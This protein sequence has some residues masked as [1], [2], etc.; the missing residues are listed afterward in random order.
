[1][2]ARQS[3]AASLRG[4]V[5]PV[6]EL[7]ATARKP[8]RAIA[9]Y[10]IPTLV[11]FLI[12][13]VGLW[14]LPGT[15]W[16]M[17]GND[18]GIWA[19]WNLSGIF[20]WSMP[21]DLSPFNPL[22]G[23]GST[24]LPNTP[25]LN[26]AA[27]AL[28]LPFPREITYL[29]SYFLYFAELTA[30]TVA[31]FRII[32]LSPL[33]SVI[34]TQIYLLVLFPP[35]NG[36]FQSLYWYS[37]APV[38]AHLVAVANTLLILLLVIGGFRR[39]GNIACGLA[40]A[41]LVLCGLFSA[42]V[43]FLTYAPTYGLAAAALLL[44]RQPDSRQ[45]LWKVGAIA[46]TAFLLWIAGF[47]DYLAATSLVSARATTFPPAFAAGAQI[48]SW[49][50]WRPALARFDVC[51][52]AQV[53]LCARYPIFWIMAGSL[54]GAAACAAR[55]SNLRPLAIGM[56]AYVVGVHIWAVADTVSLFG[57]AH[58]ISPPYLIWAAYPFTALFLG[59]LIFRLIDLLADPC[60]RFSTR[61]RGGV[62]HAGYREAIFI[63][64]CAS[65]ALIV[66]ATA[67][68]WWEFSAKQSQPP[69]PINNPRIGFLGRSATRYAQIGPITRYLIKHARIAPG[70]P[71][72]G[73][74]AS[75]F[76]DPRG[77]VRAA[78]ARE[79]TPGPVYVL[80]RYYFDQHYHNRL[81][82][83]DLW[84]H[85]IPSFEEYGQ[86]ITKPVLAA[87]EALFDPLHAENGPALF[88]HIFR[89]NLDLLPFL[90]I[91][92][93]ITDLKL[94]DPRVSLRAEQPGTDA[95][96]I[97]LYEVADSNLGNWSVTSVTT[98]QT[99]DQAMT[100]LRTREAAPRNEAVTFTPVDGRFVPAKGSELRFVRDG[101]R[102][103]ADSAGDSL[104]LL[105]VQ[106]SRCWH[107][108]TASTDTNRSDL[109][110]Y[111]ANG[112]Q[113]L[114]RFNGHVDA[115][116]KFRFGLFGSSAC[117]LEDVAELRAVGIR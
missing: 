6:T 9:I 79:A 43:T 94:D 39:R 18:D 107:L 105:P 111:R 80:A 22:S 20:E 3:V 86:W 40:I 106:Y 53:L 82:E 7:D 32:G 14:H 52:N 64:V 37:L 92:F 68:A 12:D 17:Y 73:Y 60:R 23:M 87:A 91:R 96:P 46:A 15:F 61:L 21:F 26:P 34:C 2:D 76:S 27:M 70:S 28:A 30:S 38:N 88:L 42:P 112:F 19:A 101:F 78:I 103:V 62:L 95:P 113:T 108:L 54:I 97:F 114:L 65:I 109:R 36:F 69:P 99:F 83:T 13:A 33:R 5:Q 48:F 67:F 102:I 63:G 55:R 71:F 50:Y 24:F 75:Y 41:F 72:R 84:E 11:F 66:P 8:A 1:V 104:L 89:L 117:R 85:D 44:G 47:K 29:I 74:T 81:Q 4:A 58:V 100:L 57:S 90:G 35:S 51:D 110:L 77:L 31:L 16:G 45:M 116:F 115:R 10:V 98:T 56:I 93:L 59:L 25:W 49:A